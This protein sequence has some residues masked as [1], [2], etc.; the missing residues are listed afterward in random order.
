MQDI[1]NAF[2]AARLPNPSASDNANDLDLTALPHRLVAAVSNSRRANPP[3]PGFLHH[4]AAI[5]TCLDLGRW[6]N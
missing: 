4:S 1:F 6:L 5:L 2:C 3:A